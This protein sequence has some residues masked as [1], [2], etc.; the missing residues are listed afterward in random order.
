MPLWTDQPWKTLPK[1]SRWAFALTQWGIDVDGLPG[2]WEIRGADIDDAP[3]PDAMVPTEDSVARLTQA[4]HTARAPVTF[5]IAGAQL[6][7][8]PRPAPQ[9]TSSFRRFFTVILG[10]IIKFKLVLMFISIVASLLLY[11]LAFGWEFGAALISLIA[12]HEMGHVVAN[13]IKKLPA[14]L[15]FFIPFLGA[16]IQLKELPKNAADEAFIGVMGPVFGLVATLLALAAGLYTRRPFFFAAAELGFLLHVFNL[17]PVLP[18]DGGR[19]IGFWRWKAWIPGVIGVL[20]VMFYNPLTHQFSIDP[21]AIFVI[22]IIVISLRREPKMHDKDYLAELGRL[23][24]LYT[25][26]WTVL[27]AI[28]VGGYWVVGRLLPF[29]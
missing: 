18:L 1:E 9:R 11:G 15:P 4:L 17:M 7:Y 27:F 23:R 3:A 14:S 16:F 24:W 2:S 22:A 6:C 25:I 10:L 13:R 8:R 29:I 5:D 21:I 19:T 20:V 28:S 26:L 12:I